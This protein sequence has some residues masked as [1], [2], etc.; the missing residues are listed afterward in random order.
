MSLVVCLIYPLVAT[1][2]LA[3]EKYRAR[4]NPKAALPMVAESYSESRP[5][6]AK[7]IGLGR[8]PGQSP[9]CAQLAKPETAESPPQE[10]VGLS[11]KGSGTGAFERSRMSKGGG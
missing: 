4:Q 6:Q 10:Q 1:H 2:G 8:K 11:R 5:V 7:R 9:Q 3:P